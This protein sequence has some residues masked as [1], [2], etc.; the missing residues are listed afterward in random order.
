VALSGRSAG[1]AAGAS[2]NDWH[3]DR[4]RP[5]SR[6]GT[7]ARRRPHARARTPGADKQIEAAQGRAA[8]AGHH[9]S[10]WAKCTG[11]GHF[12]WRKPEW[13]RQ[14]ED[15]VSRGFIGSSS[16]VELDRVG[17]KRG[18][19]RQLIPVCPSLAVER[20]EHPPEP[21]HHGGEE[22]GAVGTKDENGR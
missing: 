3:D 2:R 13:R 7:R 17:K 11:V 22:M 5:S 15:G 10:G 21:T 12:P 1:I 9:P 16:N 19:R 8:A 20:H 18:L 4:V 6:P 14:R